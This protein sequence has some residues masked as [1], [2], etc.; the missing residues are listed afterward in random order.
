MSKKK[1]CVGLGAVLV[2]ILLNI[3]IFSYHAVSYTHLDVYKR[4]GQRNVLPW[5]EMRRLFLIWSAIRQS[6]A[7]ILH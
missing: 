4:Q 1:L 6:R 7:G 5:W 3:C 2:W